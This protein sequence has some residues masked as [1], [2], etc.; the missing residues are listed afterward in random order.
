PN[1]QENFTDKVDHNGTNLVT[2]VGRDFDDFAREVMPV[3]YSE[4]ERKTHILPPGRPHL[5]RK[6]LDSNRFAL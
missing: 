6:P 4:E 2:I 1:S 5:S 3:L